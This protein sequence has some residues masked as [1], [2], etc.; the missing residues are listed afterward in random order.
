FTTWRCRTSISTSPRR[1]TFCAVSASRSASATSWARCRLS[2]RS[3]RRTHSP[4][5]PSLRAGRVGEVWRAGDVATR[6][7]TAPIGAVS[8]PS[9]LL[10]AAGETHTEAPA[11]A[12]APNVTT[13]HADV[14]E[15]VD[16]VRRPLPRRRAR[17][18]E[19]TGF[20]VVDRALP[21]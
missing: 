7:E 13:H 10:R 2:L 3:P 6:T 20:D 17:R 11:S 5:L 8:L 12:G 4:T 19:I 21:I 9:A 14:G 18:W 1:I 15:M 16:P